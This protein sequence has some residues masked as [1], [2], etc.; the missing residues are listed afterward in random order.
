V[1]LTHIDPNHL[2]AVWPQVSGQL[3]RAV[4]INAGEETLDQVRLKIRQRQYHLLVYT[5]EDTTL[6]TVSVA[7]FI[8]HPNMRIAHLAYAALSLSKEG[9]E[10]FKDWAKWYG[11]SQIQAFAYDAQARLYKRYGFTDTYHVMRVAL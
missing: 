10:E 6:K 9:L 11:A 7:E 3:L 5:D 8:D 1:P 4:E 2:D